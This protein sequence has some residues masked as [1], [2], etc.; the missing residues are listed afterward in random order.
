MPE[1]PL[2]TCSKWCMH[3]WVN[4]I[5]GTSKTRHIHLTMF[6]CKL[7]Q[8]PKGIDIVCSEGTKWKN[9]LSSKQTNW[10]SKFSTS[11]SLKLDSFWNASDIRT[12]LISVF[13]QISPLL[14]SHWR[15]FLC[16]YSFSSFLTISHNP[17][18]WQVS[19]S[20][21]FYIIS[22]QIPQTKWAIWDE[23]Q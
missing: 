18:K 22:H 6:K 7:S 20:L 8:K 12:E 21:H 4:S 17:N 14:V 23:R 5:N 19:F 13:N 1:T 10:G 2:D 3:C 15:D 16:V 11:L 9:I